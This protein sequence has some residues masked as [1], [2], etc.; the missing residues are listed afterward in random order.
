MASESWFRSFARDL[1]RGDSWA[2]A[3]AADPKFAGLGW[4]NA[5][6]RNGN[7]GERALRFATLEGLLNSLI[8]YNKIENRKIWK[9]LRK[10]SCWCKLLEYWGICVMEGTSASHNFFKSGSFC[11]VEK[12][13]YKISL[14]LICIPCIWHMWIYQQVLLRSFCRGYVRAAA[15]RSRG[16]EKISIISGIGKF[17]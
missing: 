1:Q 6:P 9:I 5:R 10:K 15:Y 12:K 8:F 14:N 7:R 17:D 2:R 3:A 16:V 4:L 13:T 11:G